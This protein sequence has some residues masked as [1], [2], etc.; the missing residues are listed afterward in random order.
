[1]ESDVDL[2]IAESRAWASSEVKRWFP[3]VEAILAESKRMLSLNP[4]ASVVWSLQALEVFLKNA[5]LGP[6]LR[7]RLGYDP[8]LAER[9]F[10]K[11]IE[12]KGAGVV[13]EWLAHLI[14]LPER[15]MKSGSAAVWSALFGESGIVKW[16]NEIVHDGAIASRKE[17]EEALRSVRTFVVVENVGSASLAKFVFQHR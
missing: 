5:V 9:V 2:H 14:G 3:V 12:Y 8:R 17:A 6:V 11:L 13:K 1:M 7:V 16:R 10:E 4:S 15:M